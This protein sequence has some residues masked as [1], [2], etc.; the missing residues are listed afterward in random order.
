MS[1][2][3]ISNVFEIIHIPFESENPRR[4]QNSVPKAWGSKNFST[5]LWFNEIMIS[6]FLVG[7]NL[8]IYQ[9]GNVKKKKKSS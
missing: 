6:L 9:N 1:R 8:S 4:K 5:K 7:F 2:L 3:R